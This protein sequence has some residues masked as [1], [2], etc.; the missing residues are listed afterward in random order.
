ML[1]KKNKQQKESGL[2]TFLDHFQ[3]VLTKRHINYTQLRLILKYKLLLD[4]RDTS[5][6]TLFTQMR[7]QHDRRQ[8]EIPTARGVLASMWYYGIYGVIFGLLFL[9]GASFTTICYFFLTYFVILFTTIL[10]S[11]SS[12][13]L[14]PRDRDIIGVRGVNDRTLNAARLIHVS[15]YIGS[16]ALLLVVPAIL[17]LSWKASVLFAILF[18]I[19]TLLFTLFTSFVALLLYFIILHS[20]NG[21]K[22]RNLINVFQVAFMILIYA[23]AQLPNL[24]DGLNVNF[25]ITPIWHWWSIFAFPF[26]FAAPLAAWQSSWT[27][28]LV[29]FTSAAVIGLIV[30]LGYYLHISNQFEVML[31]KLATHSDKTPRIGIWQRLMG[32]PYRRHPQKENYFNL[33]WRLNQTERDYHLRVYPVLGLT[34]VLVFVFLV[35]LGID[36]GRWQSILQNRWLTLTVYAMTFAIPQLMINLRYSSHPEAMNVFKVIPNFQPKEFQQATV[37]M[38]VSR[39]LIPQAVLLAVLLTPL[40]GW[41][42]L[43]TDINATL[44]SFIIST[45]VANQTMSLPFNAVYTA[46]QSSSLGLVNSFMTLL[47]LIPGIGLNTLALIPKAGWGNLII[48]VLWIVVILMFRYFQRT[49]ATR[50]Q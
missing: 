24:L 23:A 9:F 35:E 26:W 28:S 41:Q 45:A 31:Q 46:N 3:G 50:Y 36:G 5:L 37:W 44:Y 15:Y 20:F 47:A 16:V 42:G 34:V 1:Y 2:L 13:L 10:S 4:A 12:I 32:L 49:P 33:A 38:A 29:I 39:L 22:L 6:F 48:T 19:V 43:V 8:D 14:D 25:T 27:P 17:V 21:D 30:S 18:F 7:S 11:F 40:L